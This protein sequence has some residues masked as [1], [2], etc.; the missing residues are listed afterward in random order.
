MPFPPDGTAQGRQTV[1]GNLR[2]FLSRH[3]FSLLQGATFGDWWRLLGRH[4]FAI[5]APY[6]PRA[7]YLTAA[8]LANSPPAWLEERTYGR[9]IEAVQLRPPLFILGH[10]RSGT[11]HLHNLLS[12]DPQ[13]GYPTLLQAIYPHTFLSAGAML[14]P[15]MT[16]LMT[17]RRPQ[18][19]MTQGV[20]SPAEDEFALCAAT[21]LSPYM[22]WVF[23]RSA[24]EYD[25]YLTFR[26]A[27]V[28]E[29]ARWKAALVRFLKKVALVAD[30]PLL[31]KS[32]PHTARVRL[33]L[34]LF[35]GARFVHI[36]RHPHTVFQST[37][38]LWRAGP[39]AW[40]LQRPDGR[41]TDARIIAT[42]KA[43]YDAFFAERDLIPD[44]Q[45]C[46]VGF[47]DIEREPVRQVE[48]IYQALGLP[49]FE[50]V[51]SSLEAY[52][53]SIAGYR[54]NEYDELPA[55]LRRHLAREWR[56]GFEEWGYGG[57]R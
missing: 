10:Y 42:Y 16:L 41:D 14:A 40:Q 48:A 23:P 28:E 8:S 37:K 18:D 20:G 12:L 29:R 2:V 55:P 43:M 35:P 24:P 21:S 45:F 38:H 26:G 36:H 15:L 27:S 5:D 44:G 13:F 32:P 22:G 57:L 56:Q 46:E 17:R 39:P 7:M 25:R 54:K 34:E 30:R 50:S 11:T 31:L 33:L 49:G 6:W 1:L 19:N 4:R 51:R 9:R 52:L 53:R 3:L 47:E